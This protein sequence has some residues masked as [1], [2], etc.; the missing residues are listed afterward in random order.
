MNDT[1][2]GSAVREVVASG[3]VILAVWGALG[4]ATNALSTRMSL[5]DA[6]RHVVLGALISAGTGSLSMT[7][8]AAW[9]GLPMDQLHEAAAAGGAVGSAAY[10]VGVFGPAVIEVMLGRIRKGKLPSDERDNN[11]G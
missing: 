8:L 2:I 3:V 1:W 4:G 6:L 5:R 7:M 9:L 11:N 10:V